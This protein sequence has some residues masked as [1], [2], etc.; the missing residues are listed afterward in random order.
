MCTIQPNKKL[1][2]FY[3]LERKIMSVYPHF[4]RIF[5]MSF[6]IWMEIFQTYCVF[7]TAIKHALISLKMKLYM[8]TQYKT[9]YN[10]CGN[11]WQEV[12][13]Y[14]ISVMWI[15]KCGTRGDLSTC[16][17]HD[18]WTMNQANCD[19]FLQDTRMTNLFYQ[20]PLSILQTIYTFLLKIIL[21][22]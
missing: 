9:E 10:K 8:F 15:E 4:P 13:C 12:M 18:L 20:F 22:Q 2:G 5:M 6:K 7:K 14:R 17:Q 1:N 11:C 3:S 21:K 16:W 19:K